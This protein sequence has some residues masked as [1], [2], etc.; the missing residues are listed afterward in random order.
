MYEPR[1]DAVRDVLCEVTIGTVRSAPDLLAMAD[2]ERIA[3]GR[4]VPLPVPL[5][6]EESCRSRA[7]SPPLS[8]PLPK[9]SVVDDGGPAPGVDF[10]EEGME[11]ET[12]EADRF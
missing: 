7:C 8:A 10:A 9:G 1:A 4:R 5:P 2:V 6:A 3:F 12:C 11:K